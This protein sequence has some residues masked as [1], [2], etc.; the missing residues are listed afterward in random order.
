MRNS[1]FFLL[2]TLLVAACKPQ[3]PSDV[4]QPDE[5]EDILY[6]YHVSQAMGK[7]ELGTQAD[8]DRNK[9]FRSVL[10]K[11]GVTEAD[12]DS[13]LVYYYSRI[14]R[15]QPIY[16]RV[17]DRLSAEA[18]GLGVA[19]GELNRYS[20]YG[21]TGDTANIWKG[22]TDV[23]LIPRPT[24]NRFDFVVKADSTFMLGDSFM[25]QF[26]SEYIWQSGTKDAIVCIRSAYEGDSV[27]QTTG[28]LS[29]QGITQLHV[30]L[31]RTLKVKDMRGFIYLSAGQNVQDS[32]QM[33]FV[34]QIQLIR[35]HHKEIQ[36]AHDTVRKDTL[37]ADSLQRSAN[38]ARPGADTAGLVRVG[39][40]LPVEHAPVSQRGASDRVD[41]GTGRTQR[42][43]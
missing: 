4:I 15:L 19:T 8:I 14:D 18:K 1:L 38:P 24:K 29:P 35:F 17:S 13:S 9:L 40:R 22:E 6:D 34:S 37:Q 33:M 21:V 41:A 5:L 26:M 16:R 39:R 42:N 11:H 36:G 3:V 32:R 20:Q 43:K 2:L 12:F 27:I 23:L 10:K 30:P 28:H 7:V 25:F 31:N